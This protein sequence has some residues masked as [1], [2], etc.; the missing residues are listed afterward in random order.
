MGQSQQ[1]FRGCHCVVR[2]CR[3]SL[4]L[5]ALAVIGWD[6][7]SQAVVLVVQQH[8]IASEISG[9]PNSAHD[10]NVDDAPRAQPATVI[11]VV[12]GNTAAG[13]GFSVTDVADIPYDAPIG[14]RRVPIGPPSSYS[15][16]ASRQET[17]AAFAATRWVSAQASAP[18]AA[19]MW[20]ASSKYL[21]VLFRRLLTNLRGAR[22]LRSP[23]ALSL[24]RPVSRHRVRV[25]LAPRVRSTIS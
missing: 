1:P 9:T 12:S 7:A 16:Y 5:H 11:I 2:P 19:S 13:L 4:R 14:T 17:A 22:A 8:P 15:T 10:G 20:L 23:Y 6:L 21:F 3:L 25:L 18:S 24:G